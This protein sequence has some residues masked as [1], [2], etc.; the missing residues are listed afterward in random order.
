MWM[1]AGKVG[2]RET[3]R[4][5]PGCRMCPGSGAVTGAPISPGKLFLE[6]M[7]VDGQFRTRADGY[8][9]DGVHPVP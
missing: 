7:D 9:G 1:I 4:R 3:A 8:F 2:N 5:I 6:D